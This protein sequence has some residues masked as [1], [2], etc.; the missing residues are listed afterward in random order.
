MDLYKGTIGKRDR[1][2]FMQEPIAEDALH[3]IL[4]AGRMTPSSKNSEP[5]R[6]VVVRDEAGK[7]ALADL[8]P[9][10]RWLADAAAVVVLVQTQD[11]AFDAGRCAQNMMLAAYND[12][13]GSCPAHLPEAAL[14]KLLGIPEGHFI[15]RVIGFGFINPE[16]SGP[17]PAV[18]RKRIPLEQLT[19]HER[20]RSD[21]AH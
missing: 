6:F 10:A 16:R 14:G 8:S 18:A 7:R 11:H 19:H 12:G 20:W 5:N 1:R 4:Q 15:N 2:T 3:R 21:A 13:I 17:P 9:M